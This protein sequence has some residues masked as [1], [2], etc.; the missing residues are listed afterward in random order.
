M[1]QSL[2]FDHL[3]L[4]NLKTPAFWAYRKFKIKFNRGLG[5]NARIYCQRDAKIQWSCYSNMLIW[6]QRDFK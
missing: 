2:E 6:N 1:L 5:K 3:K 4:K